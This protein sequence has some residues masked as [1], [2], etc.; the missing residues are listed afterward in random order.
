MPRLQRLRSLRPV[1]FRH[2]AVLDVVK[3]FPYWHK[4]LGRDHIW[5]LVHDLGGRLS[6]LDNTDRIY[7]EDLPIPSSYR[8]SEI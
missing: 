5:P 3:E 7:F 2:K 6:W 1:P 8:T 4:S